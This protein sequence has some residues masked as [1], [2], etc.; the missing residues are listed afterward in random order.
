MK[1]TLK[2]IGISLL[3][4]VGLVLVALGTA[5]WLVF[6]PAR[7]TPIV[8]KLADKYITCETQ[9]ESVNLTFFKTFPLLGLDVKGVTVINPVEGAAT[10]TVAHVDR[11]TLSV[12]AMG[13]IKRGDIDVK[14][15]DVAD[16]TAYIYT[17]AQKYKKNVETAR[18]TSTKNNRPG[19]ILAVPWPKRNKN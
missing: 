4:L 10:D 7:L 17:S 12:D 19:G 15:L 13:F 8:N 3:S 18:L 2:I 5:C 6:T 14:G 16:G 11:L 1:K 9:V